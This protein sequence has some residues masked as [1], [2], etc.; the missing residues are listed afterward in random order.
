MILSGSFLYLGPSTLT[1]LFTGFSR[2]STLHT[3][4]QNAPHF[5]AHMTQSD[6]F[7]SR[8]QSMQAWRFGTWFGSAPWEDK[9]S[10]TLGVDSEVPG[11]KGLSSLVDE[12]SRG[13]E[14]SSRTVDMNAIS[15]PTDFGAPSA[16]ASAVAPHGAGREATAGST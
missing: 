14:S 10:Y 9:I 1:T 16:S 7:F 5:S 13:E 15:P 12:S 4:S 6:A 2:T 8:R 11:E 3:F